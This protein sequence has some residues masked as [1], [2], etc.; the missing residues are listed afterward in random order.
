MLHTDSLVGVAGESSSLILPRIELALAI[1]ALCS[2][3]WVL[4]VAI[5]CCRIEMAICLW[6]MDSLCVSV[7]LLNLAF[8]SSNG[9][10]MSLKISWGLRLDSHIRLPLYAKACSVLAMSSWSCCRQGAHCSSVSCLP[11][12]TPKRWKISMT[13]GRNCSSPALFTASTICE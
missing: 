2:P 8:I 1:A 3:I 6:P 12:G 9:A 5:S 4:K 10:R 13:C 7:K 11:V